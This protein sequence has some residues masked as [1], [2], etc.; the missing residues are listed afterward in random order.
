MLRRRDSYEALCRGFSWS[1]P[2]RFNIGTAVADDWAMRAPDRVALLDYRQ[3][4]DAASLTYGELADRSNAFASALKARGVGRGD[5]V[6]LLLPQC[7][8]TAI[9]HVAIYKLGAIAVPLALLFGVEALEYRLHA[10]GAKAVVTN[11]QGLAKVAGLTAQ[12]PLLDLLFSIDGAEGPA[13][14]FHRLVAVSDSHFDAEVTGPDD[15]AM[16]IFT[17]GTTGPP[18]GALHGHRVLLGHL[19]GVE[20]SHDFLPHQGDRFWTPAD[21]A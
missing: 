4:G 5:R 3:E 13:E 19:P 18:K 12:L 6:A 15:P 20:V 9:A 2:D 7:F 10:A 16:M 21:W 17:S 11:G 1:I 14:D 8:E